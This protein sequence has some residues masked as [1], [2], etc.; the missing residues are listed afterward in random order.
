[1]T[2]PI[3]P[4][5]VMQQDLAPD[6]FGSEIDDLCQQIRDATKGWYVRVGYWLQ[7]MIV[8]T[9]DPRVLLLFSFLT[10]SF[11]H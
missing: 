11:T 7:I 8:S 4:E 6:H 2:I 5:I 1:M 9:R 3:Y 10:H